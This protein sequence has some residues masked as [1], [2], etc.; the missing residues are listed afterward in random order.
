MSKLITKST[1]ITDAKISFVS[2]V[3][4]AANKRKFLITKA[5][6]NSDTANIESYGAILM[7]DNDT[8]YVTGIVY[9][10]MTADAHDDFMSAEE[11]VKAEKYFR[12]NCN[13]IDI[14]HSFEKTDDCEV[15]KSWITG[16]DC[17]I[18]GEN[19][20]E[21][22]WMLTVKVDDADLWHK[23]V[24]K[25][26]TGYSMGGVGKYSSIE[27]DLSDENSSVNKSKEVSK[28][29]L[30]TK[31]AKLFGYDDVKKGEVLENYEER[32]K[33]DNFWSA[34]S[35]LQDTLCK[36]DT[37]DSRYYYETDAGVITE[38]LSDFNNI[39]TDILSKPGG[40][41]KSIVDATPDNVK[42]PARKKKSDEEDD[43]E[44]KAEKNSG[45]SNIKLKPNKKVKKEENKMTET[46]LRS[47]MSDEIT[48][49]LDSQDIDEKPVEK[50]LSDMTES[51]VRAIF[52]EELSACLQKRGYSSSLDDE[53]GQI[54][55]EEN[56]HYLHGIL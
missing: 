52:K 33:R 44:M 56:Q 29:G 3:N 6:E 5:D 50:N 15:V 39:V 20:K 27:T 24:N 46:E 18:G 43:E 42:M 35:S 19:V 22:T 16:C 14:Q 4:K 26:I 30:F 23:I 7:A 53:E 21:G 51:E 11:I 37:H 9:E 13:Q 38:A 32:S 28:D 40:V 41:Q 34:F 36:W 25:E 48:K 10:P 17:T 55:K 45:T 12:E 49:A 31:I 1:E 47:I 8:H 2:L 54:E